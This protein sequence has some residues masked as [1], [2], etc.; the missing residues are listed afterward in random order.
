MVLARLSRLIES[1]KSTINSV[2][3]ASLWK[4]FHLKKDKWALKVFEWALVSSALPCYSPVNDVNLWAKPRTAALPQ[5]KYC[6][7]S[8][9]TLNSGAAVPRGT[10]PI[11]EDHPCLLNVV[12]SGMSVPPC[13]RGRVEMRAVTKGDFSGTMNATFSPVSEGRRRSE[14]E[15]GS[16]CEQP[17]VGGLTTQP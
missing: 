10:G 9:I 13:V 6:R 12:R 3:D 14:R 5:L 15:G 4:E 11:G 17:F 7:R 2:F 16:G 8:G 1:H